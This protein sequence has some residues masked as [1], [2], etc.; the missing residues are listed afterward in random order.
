MNPYFV[1]DTRVW[2][3]TREI[4]GRKKS[5]HATVSVNDEPEREKRCNKQDRA[6]LETLIC[7]G[8]SSATRIETLLM[9]TILKSSI[10]RSLNTLLRLGLARKVGKRPGPHGHPELI[11]AAA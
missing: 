7:C 2:N 6:V 9:G 10:R 11:W 5:Y 3:G 8:T 4:I 1:I